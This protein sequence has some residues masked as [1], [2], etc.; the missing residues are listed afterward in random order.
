MKIGF[1]GKIL[2]INAGLVCFRCLLFDTVSGKEYLTPFFIV[3]PTCAIL[4]GMEIAI[5]A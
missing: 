1:H 5:K 3:H 4:V 2:F